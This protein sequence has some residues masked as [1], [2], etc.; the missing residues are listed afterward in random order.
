MAVQETI[1]EQQKSEIENLHITTSE[2]ARRN[3]EQ[4]KMTEELSDTI[5]KKT[6]ETTI[7]VANHRQCCVWISRSFLSMHMQDDR[8]GFL[9]LTEAGHVCLGEKHIDTIN[10]QKIAISQFRQRINELELAKPP[11]KALPLIINWPA[12]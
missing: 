11:C 4:L 10:N 2:L 6:E 5:K 1:I 3:Q 9:A 12:N 8:K 7:M